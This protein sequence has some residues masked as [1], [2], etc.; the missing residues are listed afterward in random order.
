MKGDINLTQ[1]VEEYKDI[2]LAYRNY[3]TRTRVEYVNDIE[4]M[5]KYLDGVGV[6]TANDINLPHLI[7]YL[8]ELEKRGFIGSTRK[9]KTI[10]IRS[11]ISFLNMEGYILS[12][13]GKR[14]IPPYVDARKPRYLTTEELSRL[15]E[16]SKN[17]KRDYAMILLLLNTGIKLS[18]ITGLR[19]QDLHIRDIHNKN[20]LEYIWV[21]GN[22]KGKGRVITLNSAT[23]SSIKKYL[24]IRIATRNDNLFL[25]KLGHALGKRGVEK[26][27]EK[28]MKLAGIKN[29][30]VNSIRHTFGFSQ[31]AKG[32]PIKQIQTIMGIKDMRSIN[33]YN[34]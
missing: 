24:A 15:L 29:G 9:R 13:T 12:D 7:H 17:N 11:F 8:A 2:Y 31:I 30:T 5:V 23:N 19:L 18:E 4:D 3:A 22:Q 16:C 10:S 21:S 25:N 32:I 28:Y 27:I 14:L 1:A 20:E 33:I 34:Q 26:V 6:H